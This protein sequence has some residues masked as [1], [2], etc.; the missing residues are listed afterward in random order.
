VMGVY[1]LN[2]QVLDIFVMIACGIAG[3]FMMRYGYSVA[4]AALGALLGGGFERHLRYGINLMGND[5]VRFLTRPITALIVSVC[6]ALLVFG[7]YR[8]VRLQK[9]MAATAANNETE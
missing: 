1:S 9:K 2:T 3:Y 8:N 5:W 6:I 4:A 7:V